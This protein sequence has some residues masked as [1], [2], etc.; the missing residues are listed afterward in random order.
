MSNKIILKKSSVASKVPQPEDLHYGELAINYADGVLYYKN[1]NNSIQ[2]IGGGNGSPVE[3]AKVTISNTPPIGAE[4]GDLWWDS[5]IGVLFIY[6]ND[7][8][9][10]QWVEAIPQVLVEGPSGVYTLTGDLVT[11]GDVTVQ[12]TLFETSDAKLKKNVETIVDPLA[13]TKTL[14]GVNFDWVK[15]DKKSMGMIAQEV[16]TILPYLVQDDPTGTKT[17]NYTAMIGLLVESVKQLSDKV[18]QLESKKTW[19]QKLK[20]YFYGD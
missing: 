15:N 16:E 12:G 2:T 1:A 19:W 9:S 3:G 20:E 14:R 6:Y 5:E 10:S 18:E 8:D 13:L 11:T 7:G 17:I 4:P